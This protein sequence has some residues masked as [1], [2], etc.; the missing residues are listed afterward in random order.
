MGGGG[1][2]VVILLFPTYFR[3]QPKFCQKDGGCGYNAYAYSI[4]LLNFTELLYT[5]YAT[6]LSK[7]FTKKYTGISRFALLP[8]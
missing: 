1:W 7:Y 6:F 4:F 2:H 8:F 3:V 5:H